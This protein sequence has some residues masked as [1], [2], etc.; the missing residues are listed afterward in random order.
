VLQKRRD[1]EELGRQG[2]GSLDIVLDL[3]PQRV[4]L[5]DETLVLVVS[6]GRSRHG[7][8]D[9]PQMTQDRY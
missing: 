4:A 1:R 8:Y 2:L 5:G 7:P 6:G 9:E 3:L